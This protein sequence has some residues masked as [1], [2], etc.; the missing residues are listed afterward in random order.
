MRA[1]PAP[2]TPGPQTSGDTTVI[3]VGFVCDIFEIGGQEMGC[4]ELL[5]R[6]DRRV[7]SP[8]FYTFRPGALLDGVRALDIPVV[9]GHDKPGMDRDWTG[10]D[11]AARE[12]YRR[13]L[14]ARLR[15]DRID[16][17]LVY[18]W[19][20][21]VAA[22]REAGVP[23]IVERLDGPTLEK[24]IRDKTPCQRVI[25]ESRTLR[26][27]ILAQRGIIPC[28]PERLVVIPNGIDLA[29]FDPDRYDRAQCRAALGL[30]PED[31]VVGAIGRLA[32]QK[33]F[34]HLLRALRLLIEGDPA[35]ARRVRGVIIGPDG[36]ERAALEA[37]LHAL[38]LADRVRFL[39]PRTDVPDVLRALDVFAMSSRYE[40]V[41]F[42]LLEAMAMGL[43]VVATAVGS[44]PEVVDGNAYL[45]QNPPETAAALRELLH[46]PSQCERLGRRG[47]QRARE[48]DLV[49]MV[50]RYEVVL[51]EALAEGL[52]GR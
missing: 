24:R 51:Q 39:G 1:R 34:G 23:A 8:H 29:R 32:P 21:G 19:P 9:V 38:G 25:C 5:R 13:L 26:Q 40:G 4:L 6:V 50:R 33:D 47:R 11:Q 22:A 17:C 31:F 15:A 16:V 43:P 41:P 46:D 48:H 27:L 45:V 49:E 20:D 2:P 7:F 12:A 44:I 30:E 28:I 42:A 37:E 35:A 3:R 52:S 14:G 10:A 36:G 18:A